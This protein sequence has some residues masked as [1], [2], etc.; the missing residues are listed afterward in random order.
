MRGRA[1][2]RR[3]C[4]AAV[5]AALVAAALTGCARTTTGHATS[6]YDDPFRVAGL[7][8]TNGPSGARAGAPDARR[9]VQGTDDG[10][11]DRLAVNAIADLDEYWAMHFPGLFDAHAAPTVALASWDPLAPDGGEFCGDTTSRLVNAG[12][13]VADGT[14]GWDRTVLMPEVIDKF[15]VVAMVFVLAHEYGHA[16]QSA[17]GVVD[18]G[19]SATL[20]REQQADCYAGA[21]MRHVAAGESP[22]FQLDTS[23]GLNAVLA[24]TVAIG[25]TDPRDPGNVHG[26]AFERVT[27]TQIGFT[28]GPAPCTR[29]DADDI[30]ARRTGLPQSFADTRDDGELAVTED[31]V[32]RF[33]DSFARI[34]PLDRAPTLDVSTARLHC[35]DA[36]DTSPVSYCPETHTLGVDLA[37]LEQRASTVGSGTRSDLFRTSLTGDYNAYVLLASRYTLA[38]QHARG[39]DVDTPVAALRTACLSGVVTAALSSRGADVRLSPGD[40]DEAVS[41]L[42]TDGLAASDVSGRTVPSGFSRVDAFRTGVL[43]G[44]GACAGRYGA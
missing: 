41:G 31:A 3:A 16:V 8:A 9:E 18:H 12:Y 11:V 24:S 13:C 14:I 36:D 43:G 38:V 22:H 5:G 23:D 19:P 44:D 33:V 21:F 30:D 29:I 35:S 32:R 2:A 37:A 15:G 7:A 27:A 10:T 17:A 1:L 25:D 4:A 42:L 39:Q 6:I 40:L 20:V 34:L 26:T 28:D